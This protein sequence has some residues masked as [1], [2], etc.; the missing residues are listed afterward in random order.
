M[1]RRDLLGKIAKAARAAG[2]DFSQ[3]RDTGR[4]SIYRC[5][6]VIFPVPRHN[7][8]NEFTAQGIVKDLESVLG[9]GWW[10]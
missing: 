3:I 10:R 7:E 9:V 2:V 5:G 1:K 4:H 8:I 6:D